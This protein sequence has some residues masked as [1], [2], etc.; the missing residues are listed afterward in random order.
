MNP[1]EGI[2]WGVGLTYERSMC[3]YVGVR[4]VSACM[5]STGK[6]KPCIVDS[7]LY[8]EKEILWEGFFHS[9]CVHSIGSSHCSIGWFIQTPCDNQ[10]CL[11]VIV[12]N[13]LDSCVGSL[14]KKNF[15]CL[16]FTHRVIPATKCHCCAL[17]CD[18]VSLDSNPNWANSLG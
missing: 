14:L 4:Q 11:Y 16:W 7:S 5:H 1:R 18:W 6:W 17:P 15:V 8:N 12:V 10:N 2:F 3:S 9:L 13:E